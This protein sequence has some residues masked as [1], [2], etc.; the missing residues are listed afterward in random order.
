MRHHFQT[1]DDRG[2]QNAQLR[3]HGD[4]MGTE[5]VV[6]DSAIRSVVPGEPISYAESV[7]RA[8][9]KPLR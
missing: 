8:L 6:T 7:R 5:V 1:G 3:W 2:L 4:F 9:A